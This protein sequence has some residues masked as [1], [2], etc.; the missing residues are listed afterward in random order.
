MSATQLID[1]KMKIIQSK[2]DKVAS[3]NEILQSKIIFTEKSS[4]TLRKNLT[5]II[6]RPQNQKDQFTNWYNTLSD[7]VVKLLEYRGI[8][9]MLFQFFFSYS[10]FFIV[11]KLLNKIDVNLTKNYLVACHRLAN[12]DRTIIKVLNRKHAE[13]IMN[14]KSKLKGTNVSDI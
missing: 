1:F 11:T 10:C 6:P 4:K 2:F 5:P 12:F 7:N 9:L 14:N 8:F 13:Q 3:D